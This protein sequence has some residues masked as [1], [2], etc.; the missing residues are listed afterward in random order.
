MA[1][2][3]NPTL[4]ALD[5]MLPHPLAERLK[6]HARILQRQ[7]GHIIMGH[8]D[9]TT[10]LYLIIEGQARAELHSPNGREVILGDLGPG[11]L[12]GEFSALD[13]QPRTATVEVVS[14]ATLAAFP[15]PVFRTAVFAD[16]ESAEWIARRFVG[17][18]RLV[19]EKLFELNALAV[20]SRLHCELLRLGLTAGIA[21]NG[22]TIAPAPTHLE[23]AGRIGTHREAVTRELQHLP[24]EGI[25]A[26]QGRKLAI[27][28]V[29]RLAGI[30]RAAAGDVDILQRAAPGGGGTAV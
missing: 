4:D 23:L 22:A 20:R 10:E 29:A 18:I 9:R 12:I 28:D 11:E 27:H 30:I 1:A 2:N 17:H 19:T 21:D 7:E 25:V 16:P 14:P 8:G 24:R 5:R 3:A 13:D 15:G 26:Q 6:P